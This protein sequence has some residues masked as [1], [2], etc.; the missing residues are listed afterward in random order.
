[1]TSMSDTSAS[2]E[3]E[4]YSDS[5]RGLL[6]SAVAEIG[7]LNRRNVMRHF[8]LTFMQGQD[9]TAMHDESIPVLEGHVL[10]DTEPRITNHNPIDQEL[11]L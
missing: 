7:K 4:V 1:M 8:S 3:T 5:L 10:R 9:K 6:L 11:D 2:F